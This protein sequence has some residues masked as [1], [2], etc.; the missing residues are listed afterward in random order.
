MQWLQVSDYS[1]WEAYPL[2]IA[3]P[4]ASFGRQTLPQGIGLESSLKPSPVLHRAAMKAFA[5][6]TDVFLQKLIKELQLLKGVPIADRPKTTIA[7]VVLL[8]RHVLPDASPELVWHILQERL[9]KHGSRA[10]VCE[11]LDVCDGVLDPSDLQ[12]VKDHTAQGGEQAATRDK[13]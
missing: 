9:P 3:P 7:R 5:N 10:R 4:V 1:T 12:L 8:V 2:T 6:L 13:S 11:N